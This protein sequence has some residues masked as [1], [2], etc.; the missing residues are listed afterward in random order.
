MDL[1]VAGTD[2]GWVGSFSCLLS[3]VGFGL[4]AIFAKLAYGAGVSVEALLV[5]RFGLA[6]I[7]LL[8]VS[9]ATGAW[10]GMSRRTVL[11]ALAMGACGYAVQAGLYL[12]AVSQVDASQVALVFSIYPVLVMGAAISIGRDR[13]STRRLVAL[14]IALAGIVCVLGGPGAASFRAVGALLGLGSA[15]V[16]TCYILV[17]DRV[18]TEAPPVPLTA[19][20]CVGAFASCTVVGLAGGGVSL[21]FGATGWSWLVV[22]VL[23]ST[24]GAILLFFA[25]LAR[26]GPTL[27]SLLSIVEPVV[28]VAAAAAVFGER[29]SGAQY[30]GGALVLVAVVLVQLPAR[31]GSSLRHRRGVGLLPSGGQPGEGGPHEGDGLGLVVSEALEVRRHPVARD[32][33]LLVGEVHD[34]HTRP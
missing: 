7:I 34:V 20:V 11:A 25:G 23:V 19:L 13:A 4:M 33:E 32:L 5:V 17:G 22:L 31:P 30:V 6:G 29:L 8:A 2:H 3:A 18:V 26:V 15:L 21:T 27:A 24:V 16:Y 10:H 12:A 9:S 1:N 28:T 14:V